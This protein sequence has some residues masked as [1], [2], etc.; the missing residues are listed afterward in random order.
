MPKIHIINIMVISYIVFHNDIYGYVKCKL[1]TL[2]CTIFHN[3][4]GG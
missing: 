1:R 3:D 2:L 4:K